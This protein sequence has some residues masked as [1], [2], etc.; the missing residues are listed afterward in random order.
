MAIRKFNQLVIDYSHRKDVYHHTSKNTT[1][2]STLSPAHLPCPGAAKVCSD[3]CTAGPQQTGISPPS[4]QRGT[5][6]SGNFSD[7]WAKRTNQRATATNLRRQR[8]DMSKRID[9]AAQSQT[10]DRQTL[11]ILMIA[12]IR[13]IGS[14]LLF[15]HRCLWKCT[16]C[17]R[18]PPCPR[19]ESRTFIRRRQV[20]IDPMRRTAAER[21]CRAGRRRRSGV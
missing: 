11:P 13:A 21:C 8:R 19:L 2:S 1:N 7:I 4:P 9:Y 20:M 16:S 3:V 17:G 12:H 18:R 5:C 15:V 6:K 14:T 10:N